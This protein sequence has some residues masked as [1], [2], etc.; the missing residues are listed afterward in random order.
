[1]IYYLIY[2]KNI[3]KYNENIIIHT[4]HFIVVCVSLYSTNILRCLLP[5]K[6]FK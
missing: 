3:I 5:I 6:I 4:N 1:M 2:L